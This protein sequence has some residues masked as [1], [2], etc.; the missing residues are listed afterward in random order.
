MYRSV[1]SAKNFAGCVAKNFNAY[2]ANNSNTSRRRRQTSESAVTM[3]GA[4]DLYYS[5]SCGKQ[6]DI[7]KGS[8]GTSLS[9]CVQQRLAECNAL[10]STTSFTAW[11]P[12][13]S[14][15]TLSIVDT[16][17]TKFNAMSIL[18]IFGLPPSTAVGYASSNGISTSVQ[19]LLSKQ[20][21]IPLRLIP[22]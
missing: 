22:K 1:S 16:G 7:N 12:L 13:S 21:S 20:I 19:S 14:G 18:R 2:S 11:T 8:N 5:T 6:S 3:F 4:L 17:A 15:M 10:V 9:S